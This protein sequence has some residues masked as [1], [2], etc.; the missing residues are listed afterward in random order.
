M[1]DSPTSPAGHPARAPIL[2]L[3]GWSRT[4]GRWGTKQSIVSRR[5][6][7]RLFVRQPVAVLY[8]GGSW[9]G[10]AHAGRPTRDDAGPGH[11]PPAVARMLSGPGRRPGPAG[12]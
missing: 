12:C 6:S 10:R 5:W 2:S 1:P 7:W 11:G 9:A 4:G 3:A 8:D